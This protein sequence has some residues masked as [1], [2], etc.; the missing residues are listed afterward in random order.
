[1]H[2]ACQF[3]QIAPI[4]PATAT[5]GR[6]S[7]RRTSTKPGDFCNLIA[8]QPLCTATGRLADATLIAS[9]QRLDWSLAIQLFGGGGSF[10]ITHQWKLPSGRP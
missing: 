3:A 6:R 10:E 7:R 1:M 4:K 8:A 2:S 5:V 9:T